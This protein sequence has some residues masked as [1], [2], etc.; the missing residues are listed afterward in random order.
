MKFM[1]LVSFPIQL[2]LSCW[3]R[4][5][6]CL[7]QPQ[8]FTVPI[9]IFTVNILNFILILPSLHCI[10]YTALVK[11]FD[12]YSWRYLLLWS[13]FPDSSSVLYFRLSGA[14]WSSHYKWPQAPWK[15]ICNDCSR[16]L[17]IGEST[18]Q[19]PWKII[20]TVLSPI[21]SHLEQS[22]QMTFQ[23]AWGHSC[24]YDHR[25]SITELASRVRWPL[26]AF[27]RSILHFPKNSQGQKQVCKQIVLLL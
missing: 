19:A 17:P 24:M 22:L 3:V 26:D 14:I 10:V 11:P 21:G 8:Q 5:S 1:E 12:H 6:Y 27:N 18:V 4:C 20:C 15:I 13:C 9:F 7:S 25:V 23:G 2:H 16:W